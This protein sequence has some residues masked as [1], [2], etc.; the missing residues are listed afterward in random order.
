MET[1][2]VDKIASEYPGRASIRWQVPSQ[3]EQELLEALVP[4][5]EPPEGAEEIK[6][7]RSRL[8][9]RVR[10]KNGR[11][12]YLKRYRVKGWARQ[13]ASLL[14]PS[15]VKREYTICQ[16]AKKRGLPVAPV[17]GAAEVQQS[18]FLVESY[19]AHEAVEPAVSLQELLRNPAADLAPLGR[20]GLL[21]ALA[22][23]LVFMQENG[24]E[25]ADLQSSHIL[26]RLPIQL[27]PEFVLIDLD[28]A[29]LHEGSLGRE[30]VIRHLV[31][32]NRSLWG[33]AP[34]PP[35]RLQFLRELIKVH[36]RL[37]GLGARRL[38]YRVAFLSALRWGKKSRIE[39]TFYSWKFIFSDRLPPH[40]RHILKEG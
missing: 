11:S 15:K 21:K 23:F 31:Q 2:C 29:R 8:V 26:V 24:V 13:A 22:H 40:L 10:L 19:I 17:I 37:V 5:R 27:P 6:R 28:G 32:L 16:E 14:H 12:A 35:E 20:E 25:H 3:S 9:V 39:R 34:T 30:A 38:W 7:S 18:G 1:N 33:K 36:P 4:F